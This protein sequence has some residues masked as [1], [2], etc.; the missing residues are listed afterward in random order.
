MFAALDARFAH[1]PSNTPLLLRGRPLQV[2]VQRYQFASGV[3]PVASRHMTGVRAGVSR[4][5]RTAVC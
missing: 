5:V 2:G 1:A 3:E 4:T